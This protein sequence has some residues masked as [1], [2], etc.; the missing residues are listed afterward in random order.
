VLVFSRHQ[1]ICLLYI[2]SQ[3]HDQGLTC[4]SQTQ[5]S[6]HGNYQ[7]QWFVYR[8]RNMYTKAHTQTNR[9]TY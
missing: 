7:H 5:T 2:N 4:Q 9:H 1:S 8:H 3:G 6:G